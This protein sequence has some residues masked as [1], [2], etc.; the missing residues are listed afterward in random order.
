MS[1]RRPST[2]AAGAAGSLVDFRPAG[3]RLLSQYV[4]KCPRCAK[5]AAAHVDQNDV[6]EQLLVRFVCPDSCVVAAS[7]V[8]SL[9]WVHAE[10]TA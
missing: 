1:S 10:L 5:P 4:V 6:G 9:I 3:T 8:L 7:E 2:D